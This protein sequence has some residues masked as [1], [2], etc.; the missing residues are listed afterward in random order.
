[1]DKTFLETAAGDWLT[2]SKTLPFDTL[3]SLRGKPFVIFISQQ[4]GG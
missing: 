4:N 2:V 3:F 1:M